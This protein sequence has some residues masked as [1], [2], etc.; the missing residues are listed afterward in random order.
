MYY[1]AFDTET[2]GLA[3]DSNLLTAYFI[4][5]DSNFTNL[6]TLNLKI[7][8]NKYTIYP[9][10]LEINGIN[11][12]DHHNDEESVTIDEATRKLEEF[13]CGYDDKFV[14]VGHNLNFDLKMSRL[15]GLFNNNI[16][17]TFSDTII[18]TLT[19]CRTLRS[20]GKIPKTQSLSLGNIVD[21]FGINESNENYH[22]AEYD[23]L[24]TIKLLKFILPMTFL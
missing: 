10:A 8:Y 24:M 12:V 4:I 3:E 13:V 1:L 11:I 17:N 22:N 23:I 15:N 7:K 2:T 6:D 18:D 9:K 16:E 5:F 14:L 20:K 19:L 21:Y